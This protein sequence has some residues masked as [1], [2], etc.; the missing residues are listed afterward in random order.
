MELRYRLY[1]PDDVPLLSKLWQSSTEWGALTPEIVARHLENA[2]FGKPI[3][4][5]AENVTTG[6]LVGQ[7]ALMASAVLVN[8]KVVTAF[9]PMAAILDPA[10]RIRTLNPLHHPIFQLYRF[11]LEEMA[12]RGDKLVFMLPDPRW[13]RAIQMFP[14]VQQ[15]TFPLW[16]I[17]L[18]LSQPFVLRAGYEAAELTTWD[19]RVDLVFEKA[20]AEYPCMI[21]RTAETFRKKSGPPEYEVLGVYRS[22]ELVSV[23]ASKQKG[24]RQW[25]I[26]DLIAADQEAAGETLKAVCNFANERANDAHFSPPLQKAGILV[27]PKLLPIV[28]QL[29]FRRDKYDFH[30][31]VKLFSSEFSQADVDPSRWYVSA[32]D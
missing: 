20:A 29:G 31:F 1:T 2:P 9:R 6:E 18:P 11:G 17:Q 19:E 7:A 15:A 16:S 32:N 13:R 8:G 26:C 3:V 25:L 21:V 14:G 4:S 24:D 23:V 28:Q 12:R 10:V 5:V 22:G 30:L 27:V